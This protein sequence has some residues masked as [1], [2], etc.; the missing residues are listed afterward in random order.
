MILESIYRGEKCFCRRTNLPIPSSL[1]SVA[2]LLALPQVVSSTGLSVV[3]KLLMQSTVYC[4]WKERNSRIFA[5]SS[6]SVA[7]VVA[8]VDRLLRDRLVSIPSQSLSST[9]YSL[10][11]V[12]FS[13]NHPP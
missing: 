4:L 6:V 12:Y 5:G 11:Q 1:L 2:D 8:Q 3:L 9:H 7:G 10:L 13:L